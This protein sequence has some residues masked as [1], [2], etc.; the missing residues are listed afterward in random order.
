LLLR[1]TRSSAAQVIRLL[2]A[3]TLFLSDEFL[4]KENAPRVVP[5][6]RTCQEPHAGT[7]WVWFCSIHVTSRGSQ[8]ETNFGQKQ[9]HHI[10]IGAI[11]NEPH[12]HHT[13]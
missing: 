10:C 12:S 3:S 4:R 1:G 6:T 5:F 9:V 7:V 13:E 8:P 2:S 11:V